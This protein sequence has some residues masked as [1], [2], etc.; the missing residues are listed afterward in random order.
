[1]LIQDIVDGASQVRHLAALAV[2]TATW[3]RDEEADFRLL[4][5]QVRDD[6]GHVLRADDN[7]QPDWRAPMTVTSTDVEAVRRFYRAVA[8]RDMAAAESCFAPDAVW[9]L[10]GKSVI[11]GDHRGWPAIRDDF[12]AKLGPLSGQTFRAELLDVAVGREF[13]AAVQ[14]AIASCGGQRLDITG[15]Q[16]MRLEQGRI[17]E[18]RGHY[19]DQE[20][21]D[22]FWLAG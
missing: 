22:A 5:Q 20:A 11:A 7:E 21:L 18:V 9:Y 8:A 15:C 1:M 19:S 16:L 10:P 17:V 2:R 14:H 6:T 12:L 4:H 13:I 3:F